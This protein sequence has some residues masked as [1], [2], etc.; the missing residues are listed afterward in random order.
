MTSKLPPCAAYKLNGSQCRQ[1]AGSALV[2]LPFCFRHR[3]AIGRV[4]T[5][6][7]A[8]AVSEI[9]R[10]WRE[11]RAAAEATGVGWIRDYEAAW[12][13]VDEMAQWLDETAGIKR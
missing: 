5:T 11:Y 3:D 10:I 9:V 13:K 7:H 1:P 12:A 6:D 8:H 4:F 2:G